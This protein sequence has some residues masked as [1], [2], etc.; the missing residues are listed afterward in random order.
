MSAVYSIGTWDTDAQGF[1]PQLGLSRSPINCTWRDMLQICRE[2]CQMGYSCHYRR[3]PNGEHSEN[4]PMVLIERTDGM[5]LQEIL[6]QW[7]R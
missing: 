1:T 2:L 5:T 3:D 4:D 6:K 7:E